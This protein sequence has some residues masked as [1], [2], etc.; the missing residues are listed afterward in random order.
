MLTR[1]GLSALAIV[2]CAGLAMAQTPGT[3]Q[4]PTKDVQPGTPGNPQ[5]PVAP[6]PGSLVVAPPPMNPAEAP[7]VEFK[8]S[9]HDFGRISDQTEAVTKFEFK[10]NGFGKLV[11]KPEQKATCGCTVGKTMN[12]KGVQQLEF[13]PG[14]EGYLEVK[15]NAHGKRGDVQQRVT[16]QSNDPAHQP[17]GP[18]LTIKAKVKPTISFD[19]PS[20]GFGDVMPGQT[21][22]QVIKIN[23]AKPDFAIPYLST[24]KGR[25]ITTKIVESKTAEV[26]GE[27]V[28]QSTIE[29]TFNAGGVPRGSFAAV[30]TVR[31]NDPQYQ[32]A[33]FPI[34]ATIVGDL[35]TLP[36]RLNVGVI[37]TGQPFSKTFKVTSRTGKA[38]KISKIEQKS[39][40]P[41]PLEISYA[42]VEAGNETAYMVDV[43]G[44]PL[45]AQLPINATITVITD[46]PTDPTIEMI[47]S[48]AVRAPMPA[49]GTPGAPP[50]VYQPVQTPPQAPATA[51]K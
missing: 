4:P 17:E 7:K 3:D 1:T 27:Q 5:Q 20:I 10:N 40:L 16:I 31:T 21:V 23:G 14:E 37:E 18:V 15:Y 36:P 42:P 24:S 2:M 11:F 34:S 22:K 9:E 8:E 6:A 46:S 44:A 26:D 32:L 45:S 29:L 25:Y 33:D 41:T 19:P 30:A 38:F 12:S 49:A 51:P 48:G 28:G 43:K 35:Q 50:Q 39:Q 13:M 47:L